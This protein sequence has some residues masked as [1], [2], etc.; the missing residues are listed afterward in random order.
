M[1]SVVIAPQLCH[2]Y[3]NTVAILICRYHARAEEMIQKYV[4]KIEGERKQ[5]NWKK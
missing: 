2:V 1:L 5:V 3:N 4:K